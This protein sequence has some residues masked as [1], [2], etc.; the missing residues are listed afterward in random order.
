MIN[1]LIVDD[2]EDARVTLRETIELGVPEEFA[3]S[4][5][6]TFPLDDVDAYPSYIR[7]HDIAA[8]LLDERLTE[9]N[10]PETGKYSSY[11]GHDVVDRLRLALPDFPVY[12][13]TTH[14]EDP[15][16][17]ENAGDFEDVVERDIFQREPL[18][19]MSRISRA[20]M[21]FQETMQRRLA[22]LNELTLK[23][24]E[25]VLSGEEQTR[26]NDTRTVLGLPFTAG[27]DLVV[28][29]L[30]AEAR[31]LALRSSDLINRIR[32]EGA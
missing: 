6:D 18:K 31:V 4:I 3:I 9:V 32:G 25:G 15:V 27:S 16:L 14:N 8:L 13:V 20:A 11:L 12:V 7:E 19:Y 24:A 2:R 23:A 28:S 17:V 5:I 26:L 1:I 30:I 29:D 21:R 10:S 22:E